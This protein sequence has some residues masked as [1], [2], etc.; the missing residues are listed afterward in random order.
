MK[1]KIWLI[2]IIFII[3]TF[4]VLNSC[5]KDKPK[6][7]NMYVEDEIQP[8]VKR[9]IK[10]YEKI[11]DK[12]EIK[13]NELDGLKN[14]DI[15]IT[16]DISK[17]KA[18]KRSYKEYN[19]M[20]DRIVVIGRRKINNFEE[21]LHS[22]IAVPKYE[23]SLGK[24]IIDVLSESENFNE[25]AG[26]IN[27]KEDIIAALQSVDLYEVDYAFITGVAL[28]LV[29]NSE[30]CYKFPKENKITYKI[31]IKNKKDKEYRKI[32]DI[33]EDEVLKNN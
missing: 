23:T 16:S 13:Y 11:S 24:M 18:V 10:R 28:P 12:V 1:R 5:Q 26:K 17:M 32:Y 20:E 21:L 2:F 29:K 30:V 4:A 27:Y 19:F 14:Y 31:Y 7:I 9:L 8:Y 22:T 3:G 6:I 33:L 25:I 15:I